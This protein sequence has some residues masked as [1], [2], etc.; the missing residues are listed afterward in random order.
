[1]HYRTPAVDLPLDTL[2][3]FCREMAVP[4]SPPQ[5]RLQVTRASV[6]DETSVVI[7]E[8]RR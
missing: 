7:L 3:R 8:Y 5:P 4:E 2:E 6:P 1:M